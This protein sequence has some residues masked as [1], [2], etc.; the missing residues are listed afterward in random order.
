MKNELKN[1]FVISTTVKVERQSNRDKKMSDKMK[2]RYSIEILKMSINDNYRKK[3]NVLLIGENEEFR[4]WSI[5][6]QAS[7]QAS[8]LME[9]CIVIN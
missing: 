1:R 4:V 9:N 8:K 2:E 7:K 3:L 6:C 5:I